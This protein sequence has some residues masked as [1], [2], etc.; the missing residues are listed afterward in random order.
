M[1]QSILMSPLT[2][3]LL[4]LG[5]VGFSAWIGGIATHKVWADRKI[6]QMEAAFAE[7]RAAEAAALQQA[8]ERGAALD[9]RIRELEVKHDAERKKLE[10]TISSLTA[11]GA[12]LRQQLA[13]YTSSRDASSP[14][15]TI[16]DLRHRVETL[17]VLVGEFD[18]FAEE[19]AREVERVSSELRLCREYVE[20]V[21]RWMTRD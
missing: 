6:A 7:E 12:S 13:A 9:R 21:Q 4:W 19:S 2:S 14:E 17:G 15:A 1:W 16:R 11:S 3:R 20:E 8:V 10:S 18:Q 5:V